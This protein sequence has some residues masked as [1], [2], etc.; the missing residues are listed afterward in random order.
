MRF[1]FALVGIAALL[2]LGSTEQ[3]E[4]DFAS[5]DFTV[6]DHFDVWPGLAM[7][8]MYLIECR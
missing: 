5:A 3:I 1:L 6:V 4:S 7:W 2:F 8:R